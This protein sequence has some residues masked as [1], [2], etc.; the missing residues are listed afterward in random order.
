MSYFERFLTRFSETRSLSNQN[1]MLKNF[2]VLKVTKN[3]EVKIKNA[4]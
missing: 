1:C 2:G 4:V 3:I